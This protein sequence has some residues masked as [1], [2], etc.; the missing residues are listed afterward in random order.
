MFGVFTVAKREA[1]KR[2]FINR[3]RAGAARKRGDMMSAFFRGNKK[4]RRV[5]A[6]EKQGP[7]LSVKF[8]VFPKIFKFVKNHPLSCFF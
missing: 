2:E 3:Y 7:I 5:A 8:S 6:I 1:T 4:H